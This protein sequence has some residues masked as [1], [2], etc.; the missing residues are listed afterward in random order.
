MAGQNTG[1]A[2]RAIIHTDDKPT[3]DRNKELARTFRKLATM[4]EE[5]RDTGT[6]LNLQGQE[7]GSWGPVIMVPEEDDEPPTLIRDSD[8][9]TVATVQDQPRRVSEEELMDIHRKED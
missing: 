1:R 9:T 3:Q 5:G 6:I 7:V 8:G 4:L 2:F